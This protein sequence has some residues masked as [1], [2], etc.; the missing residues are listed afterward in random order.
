[1]EILGGV[2]V[3]TLLTGSPDAVFKRARS[4]LESGILRGGR[5]ILREGNNLPPATPYANLAAMYTAAFKW[6][7][8]PLTRPSV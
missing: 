1:M 5:F 6:G 3:T 2:E 4:I 8:Y 7:T